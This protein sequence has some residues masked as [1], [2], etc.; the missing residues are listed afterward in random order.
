MLRNGVDLRKYTDIALA[1]FLRSATDEKPIARR[2][3]Y[4]AHEVGS[5]TATTGNYTNACKVYR[6]KRAETKIFP[7]IGVLE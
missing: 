4:L 5:R 7:Q 3:P 1:D 6:D 2:F